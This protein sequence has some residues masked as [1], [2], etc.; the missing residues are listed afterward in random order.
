MSIL[1]PF[2]NKA[3]PKV[4]TSQYIKTENEPAKEDTQPEE[5]PE[6]PVQPKT[7]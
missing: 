7:E 6:N 1:T 3:Q 2:K 5:K 4:P